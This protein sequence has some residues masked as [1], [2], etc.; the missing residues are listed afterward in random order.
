VALL[1][2]SRP[3]QWPKNLLVFAAPLAAG[4]LM[5]PEVL[6]GSMV[7]LAAMVLASVS[8][9]LVNDLLDVAE[10]RA[11]PTKQHRPIA[12]G[13]LSRRAAA[14]AAITAAAASLAIP[15]A[16]G[17][18]PLTGIVA[19]YLCVQVLYFTWAKSQ[20][21]FDLACVAAGFVLRAVAGGVAAAI[22]ISSWF[23]TV[24]ASVAVFV[25][26]GKRYSELVARGAAS[27]KSLRLYSR[28][29][30]RFVWSVSAAVG[31]VFYA[32]WANELSNS[33]AGATARISIIPFALL[34]LRYARDIDGA[35]AE[36]PE[37]VVLFDP[38]FLAL[39]ALWAGLF[40]LQTVI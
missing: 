13:H 18:L 27:R 34:L 36:S 22:P 24:T 12:A 20:P 25:V 38:E 35:Q 2:A 17:L 32:L 30:L 23:L 4:S 1:R 7:A 6:A 16:L 33:G 11:H 14:V 5:D 8:T 37:S 3:K 28:G 31:I 29:Y 26:A 15:A 19:C 21:V 39:G 40:F 10:D 9:Y